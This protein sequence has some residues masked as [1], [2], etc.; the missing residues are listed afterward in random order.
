M[1]LPWSISRFETAQFQKL[2]AAFIQA[3][4][5]RLSALSGRGPKS[6]RPARGQLQPFSK[7]P[8]ASRKKRGAA[9]A[10]LATYDNAQSHFPPEMV[11][12]N[13]SFT[14]SQGFVKFGKG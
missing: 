9:P 10:Y 5:T 1:R 2:R 8:P 4:K 3:K 13:S 14:F 7:W 12:A 11:P 6:R